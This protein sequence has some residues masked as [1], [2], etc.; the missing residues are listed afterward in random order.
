M[1][2]NSYSA[3]LVP[4]VSNRH[5]NA[6]SAAAVEAAAVRGVAIEHSGIDQGAGMPIF[7]LLALAL[8]CRYEPECPLAA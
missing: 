2:Q 6:Q 5:S 3:S 7:A 8:R 1:E 4:V